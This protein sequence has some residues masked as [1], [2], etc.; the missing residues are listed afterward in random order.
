MF[1][2]N[3]KMIIGTLA[4]VMIIS[5]SQCSNYPV[6]AQNVETDN[7]TAP[8]QEA[9]QEPVIPSMVFDIKIDVG[10]QSP[11]NKKVPVTLTITPNL[12]SNRTE[13]SWDV[14]YGVEIVD[15][16]QNFFSAGKG[17]AFKRKAYVFPGKPGTYT[18]TANVTNWGYGSNYT[19][20]ENITLTFGT[21][22]VTDPETSSYTIA[23][24]IRYTVILLIFAS[25]IAGTYFGFRKFKQPIKA[26]FKPPQ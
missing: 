5:L 13:V 15:K 10:T 2:N 17:E 18:I 20:S 23:S 1:K 16:N 6:Y 25:I 14:P 4:S 21:N 26:W 22:L 9:T 7:P 19:S 24:I 11:W 12:D 3:T 8:N